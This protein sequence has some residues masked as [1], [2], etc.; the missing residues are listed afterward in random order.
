MNNVYSIINILTNKTYLFVGNNTEINSLVNKINNVGLSELTKVE[1]DKVNKF[2]QISS[3]KSNTILVKASINRN[4]TIDL[5]KKKI[6]VFC[7]FLPKYQHLWVTRTNIS[8]FYKL[9]L[10]KTDNRDELCSNKIINCNKGVYNEFTD[11]LGV[12][13]STNNSKQFIQCDITNTINEHENIYT[14]KDNS[15][16]MLQEYGSIA[17]NKIYLINYTELLNKNI[18]TNLEY[19]E[20]IYYPFIL[21]DSTTAENYNEII[22]NM[23]QLDS[24][25]HK[26]TD[27]ILEK[28]NTIYSNIILL[29]RQFDI[30]IIELFNSVKPN[31]D[32]VFIKYISIT[33]EEQYKLQKQTTTKTKNNNDY[34]NPSKYITTYIEGKYSYHIEKELLEKWKHTTVSRNETIKMSNNT[35]ILPNENQLILK[36]TYEKSYYEIHLYENRVIIRYTTSIEFTEL[37]KILKISNNLLNKIITK[38]INITILDLISCDVD[39]NIKDKS[40]SFL[41]LNNTISGY[42]SHIYRYTPTNIEQNKIYLKY[43][44]VNN[45]TSFDNIRRY[46]IKLRND[47]NISIT[48][49]RKKWISNTEDLFYISNTDSLQLLTIINES[50][51]TDELKKTQ[52]DIEVTIIIT[53]YLNSNNESTFNINIKNC[54]SLELLEQINE[55]IKFIFNDSKKKTTIQVNTIKEEFKITDSVLEDNLDDDDFIDL[56]NLD[57]E[58]TLENIVDNDIEDEIEENMTEFDYIKMDKMSIRTYMTELR[59]RDNALI[60]YTNKNFK[61][62]TKSCGAATAR[63]PIIITKQELIHFEK[64]NPIGYKAL[65]YIEWGSSPKVKN[66]FICPRIWC[67]RDKIALSDEQFIDN[68]G[69]CPFCQGEIIDNQIIEGNKTVIIR[70][71]GANRFWEDKKIQA[72]KSEKWVKFLKRTEKDAHP[73]LLDPKLHPKNKCMPCCF[74]K[75]NRGL[76][77]C[78]KTNVDYTT[79]LSIEPENIKIGTVFDGDVL[80]ENDTLLLKNT[81]NN[82]KNNVYIVTKKGCVIYN[83]ITKLDLFLK[84]GFILNITNGSFKNKIYETLLYRK[85]F[86][87]KEKKKSTTVI[88]DKYVI[89]EDKFPIDHNKMGLIYTKLDKLLNINSS[90]FINDSKMIDNVSMFVRMG[91][92]QVKNNSFLSSMASLNKQNTEI[93]INNIIRE[94]EP[95]DFIGLNNGDIF[96]LFSIDEETI[97]IDEINMIN[98]YSWC[99]EYNSFFYFYIKKK[100]P[101]QTPSINS[102]INILKENGT[103]KRLINIY[104]SFENF[105]KYCG[106]MNIYKEPLFFV[107]LLSRKNEWFFKNGLNIIIFEKIINNKGKDILYARCPNYNILNNDRNICM[108]YKYREHYEPIVIANNKENTYIPEFI[109]TFNKETK[110]NYTNELL[111]NKVYQLYFMLKHNCTNIYDKS[112]YVMYDKIKYTKL[113]SINSIKTTHTLL[114]YITDEYYKGIGVMT[115]N[116]TIIFTKPFGINTTIESKKISEIELLDYET[117]LPR[118]YSNPVSLIVNKNIIIAIVLENGGFHPVKNETYNKKKHKL[119][120]LNFNY[121]FELDNS[122]GMNNVSEFVMDYKFKENMYNNLKRE[123]KSFMSTKNKHLGKLKDYINTLLLDP[124]INYK[125]MEISNIVR[126]IVNNITVTDK[127]IQTKKNN[128]VCNKLSKKKCLNTTLCTTHNSNKR[129]L[130][131]PTKNIKLLFNFNTCKLKISE[132]LIDNFISKISEEILFSLGDRQDLLYGIILTNKGSSVIVTG[133]NYT[134]FIH[135]L[136][137]VKNRYTNYNTTIDLSPILLDKK[138]IEIDDTLIKE[139]DNTFTQP[140]IDISKH[141]N[142]NTIYK[143]IYGTEYNKKGDKIQDT[144]VL[145]GKCIFPFKKNLNGVLHTDCIFHKS[146]DYGRICAT[147]VDDNNIMTKY[148]FCN[149]NTCNSSIIASDTD[150]MGVKHNTQDVKAGPCCF[151]FKDKKFIDNSVEFTDVNSCIE[152]K[153]GYGPIC[154]TSLHEKDSKHRIKIKTKKKGQ[155]KTYGFCPITKKTIYTTKGAP[156]KL[157]FVHKNK[158]QNKCVPLDHGT[159]CPIK[160]TP[161]K[162]VLLGKKRGID[163][164]YCKE[165]I[166]NIDKSKWVFVENSF[167]GPPKGASILKSSVKFNNI[168]QAMEECRKNPLCKGITNDLKMNKITLRISDNI[169]QASKFNGHSWIKVI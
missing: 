59:K 31:K 10:S 2:I 160:S 37:D 47:N 99:S 113:E 41:K 12:E 25:I 24:K 78:T 62:W 161:G 126:F 48:Q 119:Q 93:L 149:D 83:K 127:I 147:Q 159:V 121:E 23:V 58:D 45:F 52:L 17:D 26:N 129:E 64:L 148:A 85:N 162:K 102:E 168:K 70:R 109:W 86:V 96:K 69:K 105:K 163:Y 103:L 74:I 153:S 55:F 4:D 44:K 141:N 49:F 40:L 15:H 16:I 145:P 84:N 156:C 166:S 56:D 117:L 87:F 22:T 79:D 110:I 80:S 88:E 33:G 38:F 167:L 157:P 76:D 139:L 39:E 131:I 134:S 57:L 101:T 90:D 107:D 82:S 46:L 32:I 140:D 154:A 28:S 67:I 42:N 114:Y 27:M 100:R 118:L 20:S 164:D 115:D 5:I 128:T 53:F 111:I 92:K 158:L 165:D 36:I 6:M 143:K 81:H 3:I 146:I 125:R 13:Y 151:P 112:M 123:F 116:N 130:T 95:L 89:G 122:D 72:Q 97:I 135:D 50:L 169:R 144:K 124:D 73:G 104:L 133:D 155:M 66:Y 71:G 91:I 1:L 150:S 43:K 120:I 21:K 152:S 61:P 35:D 9:L 7:D 138:Q 98:L 137:D 142:T 136:F 60:N 77:K 65:E 11:I 68:N 30:N 94:I 54:Y 19:I 8:Q 63:Q 132:T 14:F 108:L 51:D 106:D 29:S 34:R 18:H 75:E